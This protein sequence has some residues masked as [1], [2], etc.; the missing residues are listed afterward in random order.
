MDGTQNGRRSPKPFLWPRRGNG[1]QRWNRTASCGKVFYVDD[2]SLC[3]DSWDAMYENRCENEGLT[4]VYKT[5]G[6]PKVYV[7]EDVAV[8]ENICWRK[9]QKCGYLER[10]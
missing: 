9:M 2:R 8:T 4:R 1:L 7:T 10:L 6:Q 3:F 5:D